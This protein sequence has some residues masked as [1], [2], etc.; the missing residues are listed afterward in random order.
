MNLSKIIKIEDKEALEVK[1]FPLKQLLY[2][3]NNIINAKKTSANIEDANHYE[4][5]RI[6]VLAKQEARMIKEK[7]KSAAK[8][9]EM[10]AMKKGL[11]DGERAGA[12]K[13]EKEFQSLIS[14]FQ[15]IS[16]KFEEIKKTYYIE[17]QELLIDL[18]MKIARKVIHQEVQTKRD[19]VVG[20]LN[21]AIKL[22]VDREKLRIRVNPQDLDM[23]LKKRPDIMKDIDGIKQIFFE[24]DES[25]GRGGGIVEY[26]FGE[27]DARIEHQFGEIKR[28]LDK[29]CN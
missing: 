24:P 15:N 1:A 4:K 28:Q 10:Q 2:Y 29:N 14:T 17:H 7:A 25:I 21:S 5:E 6:R 26:A 12:Q 23:C 3:E 16:G 9:I 18:A 11:A 19:L 27:I 8:E 13:A 22:A 20:V